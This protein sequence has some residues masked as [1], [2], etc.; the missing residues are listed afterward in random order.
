MSFE[1]NFIDCAHPWTALFLM[2]IEHEFC[3][4]YIDTEIFICF[5]LKISWFS[6]QRH[7]SKN[8]WDHNKIIAD[9]VQKKCLKKS[10]KVMWNMYKFFWNNC[11]QKKL[12]ILDDIAKNL[13]F[14]SLE[15]YSFLFR[16]I[17]TSV[18]RIFCLSLRK[19]LNHFNVNNQ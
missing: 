5:S 8:C 4:F 12:S 19:N 9:F 16:N 14:C 13:G 15:K 1:P 18:Y 2:S 3:V 7:K 10:C 17:M 11:R 6:R